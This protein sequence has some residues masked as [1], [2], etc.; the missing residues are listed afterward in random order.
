MSTQ[1]S[2]RTHL[3]CSAGLCIGLL[4]LVLLDGSAMSLAAVP[5][6]LPI[7][8]ALRTWWTKHGWNPSITI[9]EDLPDGKVT[10]SQGRDN[11]ET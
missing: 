1:S 4:L 7:G 10:K 8:I 6:G 5:I 9:T 3:L 11:D 2:K